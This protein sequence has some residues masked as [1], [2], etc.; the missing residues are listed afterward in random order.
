MKYAVFTGATGGLGTLCVKELSRLGN[1]TVFAGGTNEVELMRLGELVNI[2][3]VRLD[4]TKQESVDA[5]LEIIRS[6]TNKLDAIV[7]FAGLTSFTSLIEG[8]SVESIEKLLNVN[9]IGMARVN[10]TFFDMIYKGHG[11]IINCSSESGWMTPQPF[12]G[13]YVLSKYAVD[14]YNDSLRRELIYLGIPVIKIQPGSYETNITQQVYK[15]FDKVISTTKYYSKLL[16]KM[17]PLMVMELNQKN[18]PR[19]LVK[20]VIRAMEA[21]HP[22]LRYRVG[23]GR[24]LAMLELLPEQGVDIVYK[25]I[26]GKIKDETNLQ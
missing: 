24:L 5:A 18:D 15:N 8:D 3:P 22:K 11:R 2:I 26:F 20:T 4:V 17:K 6:Y 7:N 23:T 14:A 21:R 16:T 19:R 9:M 10:R 1:W 13:P 12:A 25:L